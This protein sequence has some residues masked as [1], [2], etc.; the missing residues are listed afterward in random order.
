MLSQMYPSYLHY[1]AP[2]AAF[3]F[4]AQSYH[5][6]P[7]F[8]AAMPATP[9]GPPP[10]TPLGMP[11]G[12]MSIPFGYN[13][14]NAQVPNQN[15]QEYGK[16]VGKM[17]LRA[18]EGLSHGHAKKLANKTTS[19]GQSIASSRTSNSSHVLNCDLCSLTFPSLSVLNNHLKGSRHLRKVKS[20]VAY[21][22]MKAAGMQFKQ[23]Q[24]E[25][26]CEVCR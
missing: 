26:Q 22:Q 24:G 6:F 4:P 13:Y 12:S 16:K 3:Y 23:D 14:T 7:D 11:M 5:T 21:K 1:T 20:Q 19:S 8:V 15:N 2:P 10:N 18:K 25:I 9:S 17:G